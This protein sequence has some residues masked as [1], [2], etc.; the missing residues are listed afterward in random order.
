MALWV[1]GNA[2]GDFCLFLAEPLPPL[3]SC[4]S[5][6][7][8][9]I[10]RQTVGNELV[11][12]TQGT[13]QCWLW[14]PHY[15]NSFLIL[16]EGL[17]ARTGCINGVPPKRT[18]EYMAFPGLLVAAASWREWD[19]DELKVREVSVR[20]GIRWGQLMPVLSVWNDNVLCDCFALLYC[21]CILCLCAQK[22]VL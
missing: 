8:P 22:Q 16:S 19:G 13:Q 12:K 1:S 2:A 14:F 3:N 7:G 20:A 10:E 4:S 5:G 15:V 21:R 11:L 9:A 17:R 18:W 6:S